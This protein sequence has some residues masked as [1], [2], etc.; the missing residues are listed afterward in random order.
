LIDRIIN[1]DAPTAFRLQR[2]IHVTNLFGAPN[3][4]R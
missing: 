3:Y 2:L 4:F 1:T